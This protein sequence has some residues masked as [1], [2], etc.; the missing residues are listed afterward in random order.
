MKHTPK[1]HP[2]HEQ[3]QIAV[4]VMIDVASSI[5]ERKRKFENLNL[6]AEW[7]VNVESW[8]VRK[9]DILA[10]FSSVCRIQ[11]LTVRK[12][13]KKRIKCIATPKPKRFNEEGNRFGTFNLV[14]RWKFP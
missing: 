3:L 10:L 6:I 2:D 5:N 7:Q 9:L 12:I 4:Q 8:Q 14:E 1:D 11:L 13:A